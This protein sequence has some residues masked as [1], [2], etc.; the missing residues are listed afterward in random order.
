MRRI[1]FAAVINAAMLGA[2][3]PFASAQDCPGSGQ[4]SIGPDVIVGCI[5]EFQ[6]SFGDLTNYTGAGGLDAFSIGTTSCNLGDQDVLWESAPDTDHP[7]ISQNLFRLKNVNGSNRFEQLG[8]SW[9]KH[10][11]A[12]LAEQTC[13]ATCIDPGDFG[14]LGVGCSDPYESSRNGGQ[15]NA[16][17]RWQVNATTGIHIQPQANPSFSGAMARRLQVNVSDLEN[18]TTP[19]APIKYFVEAQYT[20]ADDAA[21][22]NKYNNASYRQVSV[23]QASATNYNFGLFGTNPID[24]TH[25]QRTGIRAWKD[26]DPGVIETD[27]ITPE[28]AN[29]NPNYE[30]ALVILAAEATD[31]G[32]GMWHYEYAMQ[33]MNSDRSVYSFSVPV[34]PGVNVT[35]IGFHDVAY[36]D[37]DGINDV[38][39]DGTDWSGVRNS[40][41]VTWVCAS[42]FVQDPNANALRWGTLYNFRFDANI[43]PWGAQGTVTLGQF[44][45]ANAVTASSVVPGCHCNG[46]LNGSGTIDGD[47]IALFVQMFINA[48]PTSVCADTALPNGGNLDDNDVVE[49]TNLLLAGINCL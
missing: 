23:T 15:F 17:P 26:N 46:D 37:G 30:S 41:D 39:R 25:K 32:G 43:A 16:G 49:F 34:E 36:H 2:G 44:T 4:Q 42:T 19:G 6:T 35:N 33:N 21:A 40:N 48:V 22:G 13:C 45:T 9:L 31:L 38:T 7:V 14:R 11:F 18:S 27:I 3:V 10:G 24:E 47:D 1:V 20:T 29:S 5:S 28:D 12:A 8:M